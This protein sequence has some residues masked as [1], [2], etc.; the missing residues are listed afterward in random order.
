MLQSLEVYVFSHSYS[1][2]ESHFKDFQPQTRTI[3]TRHLHVEG[4]SNPATEQRRHRET[5]QT[6]F[7]YFCF[8]Y[9]R[10]VSRAWRDPAVGLILS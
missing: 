7:V 10:Y 8:C 4:F 3:S 6:S 1:Q 9:F 2:W 5:G